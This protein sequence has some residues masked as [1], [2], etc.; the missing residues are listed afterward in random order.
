MAGTKDLHREGKWLAFHL[1]RPGVVEK[2][3]THID[4]GIHS[5]EL[6]P[7]TPRGQKL[8]P[9]RG[10]L[11]LLKAKPEAIDG[12][13]PQ[14]LVSNPLSVDQFPLH[15]IADDEGIK[16]TIQHSIYPSLEIKGDLVSNIPS[17][18][19]SNTELVQYFSDHYAKN[20][21][22]IRS[23]SSGVCK[24]LY[25]G[26]HV[27]TGFAIRHANEVL[28]VTAA[29]VLQDSA[30]DIVTNLPAEQF[31]VQFDRLKHGVKEYALANN[32]ADIAFIRLKST[33]AGINCLTLSAHPLCL[34]P[35]LLVS[36][37][38]GNNQKEPN[39]EEKVPGRLGVKRHSPGAI[40]ELSFY[41]CKHD[42]A[43]LG[44]SSGG[45]LID[46][47][48]GTVLAIHTNGH[49]LDDPKGRNKAIPAKRIHEALSAPLDFRKYNS[50]KTCAPAPSPPATKV[51]VGAGNPGQPQTSLVPPSASP[52]QPSPTTP[53]LLPSL[54][55]SF[56]K[57]EEEEEE[58]PAD[59]YL[60]VVRAWWNTFSHVLSVVV[61]GF[62]AAV[63][64]VWQ[65][66]KGLL[67]Y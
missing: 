25:Q 61:G 66:L 22:T 11:E 12:W 46:Y 19:Q 30:N 58:E 52:S 60:D 13:Y 6:D 54:I 44:G 50:K 53:S 67:G 4:Q 24:I 55:S 56:S 8:L 17:K 32:S 15:T 10:F 36:Y 40:R 39:V 26:S 14:N 59:S 45:P 62:I 43:S 5:G 29:H 47:P 20:K 42:C 64:K 16:E 35:C 23:A 2:L 31:S 38:G 63:K 49:K 28:I 21:A 37:P 51:T 1:S 3:I 65:W 48:T 34:V 57:N 33:P 9:F 18:Y 41:Y 7:F 27:G